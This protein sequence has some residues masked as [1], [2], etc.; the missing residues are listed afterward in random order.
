MSAQYMDLPI[1]QVVLDYENPRIARML[2]IYTPEKLNA[3]ALAIALGSSESSYESL[4][5]SIR[6]NGGIIHPIIV[7]KDSDGKYVVVEGNTRV[8]I[9][10][11]FSRKEVPGNWATIRALVYNCLDEVSVHSIRLQAHLVGPREWDPYS[12]AKYLN[13]LQNEAQLPINLIISYCGGNTKASEVKNMIQA[14]ND[15]EEYYRPLTS[16]DSEFDH[17]KFSAFDELQRKSIL[18]S[19]IQNNFTKTDFS[20]WII[21]GNID[22]LAD[23]RRL[24]DILRS[25]EAKNVFLCENSSEAIKVL[26]VEEIT[27][28]KLKDVPY[29]ML[30]KELSKRMRNITHHEIM[31]LKTDSEYSDKLN[32]LQSVL[33]EVQF[34]V[35]EIQGD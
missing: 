25:T 2:E 32:T 22:R 5:E 4:K 13:Y 12:K 15:M 23:V 3:D 24:P 19:I 17:K 8:Q 9:Y 21:E 29:E 28:D 26:A 11:E 20:K 33:D 35:D 27:F 34:V 7:N 1:G 31:H 14:Y 18:D 16:D 10:R 6:I 30:A